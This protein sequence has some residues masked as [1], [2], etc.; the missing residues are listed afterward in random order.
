[1]TS[2]R[3]GLLQDNHL[4]ANGAM[5]RKLSICGHKHRQEQRIQI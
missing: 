1:M 3:T 5:A 4:H 2:S